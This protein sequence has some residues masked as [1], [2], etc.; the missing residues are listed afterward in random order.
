MNTRDEGWNQRS[1]DI[2]KIQIIWKSFGPFDECGGGWVIS[3]FGF[4]E[5][6]VYAGQY[7]SHWVTVMGLF[8]KIWAIT[9]VLLLL[10]LQGLLGCGDW[11]V[12]EGGPMVGLRLE[13]GWRALLMLQVL[14]LL[15]RLKFIRDGRTVVMSTQVSW[16]TIDITTHW[17]FCVPFATCALFFTVFTVLWP[18]AFNSFFWVPVP[19]LLLAILHPIILSLYLLLFILCHC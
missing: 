12:H 14:F 7:Q 17:A 1:V 10:L 18:S 9:L 19:P 15:L 6:T 3:I 5:S 11:A 2:S 16:L 8:W 4:W 13:R